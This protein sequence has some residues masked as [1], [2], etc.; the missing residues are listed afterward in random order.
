MRKL[1]F[2]LMIV[3]MAAAVHAQVITPTSG[4]QQI[5]IPAAGSVTG[6][7]GQVFRSDINLVNFRASD[8]IVQLRWLPAGLTGVGI[9]PVQ[10][11]M[12]AAS[13]IAS[14]DFVTNVLHQTGLGAILITGMTSNGQFD[15]GANLVATSRI[16]SNQPGSATG[17]VSQT[18]P[19]LSTADINSTPALEIMGVHN[20][21]RYRMNVGIVNLDPNNTHIF[22]VAIGSGSNATSAVNVSVDPFSMRQVPMTGG[23]AEPLQILINDVTNPSFVNWTAYASS[24]DN[25][26]G[27]SWSAIG[28]VPKVVTP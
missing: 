28:F 13:G 10:I 25:V 4:T 3:L 12:P 17:T 23:A 27:D 24:V 19:V 6:A 2:V 16:W 8:Q 21:S 22:R 20:D 26:T 15:F 14:E 5:L 9:A 1:I 11:T 7:N 18:F